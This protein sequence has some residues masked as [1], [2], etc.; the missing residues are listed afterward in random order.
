V[1]DA[2]QAPGPERPLHGALAAAVT[3]LAGGG[4]AV[5]TTGVARLVDFYAAAG[6]DGLLVLGTTGEGVLLSNDERKLVAR[7]YVRAAGARL[8]VAVHCGAQSSRDTVMLAAHAAAQGAAAVAVIP[9][10]YFVLD[11]DALLQHLSAAATACA[12][13][14]FYV[15]EFAARSG[16]AVPLAV[17]AALQDMA[18]NFVGLKVSDS[19]FD[20]VEPYLTGDL[21]VLVGAEGS[22]HRALAAGA[23][24]AV[25]G[26]AAALPELT[27]EAVRTGTAEASARAE[28]VRR[29]IERFPFHAALKLILQHR[30]VGIAALVRA[31]LRALTAGERDE[32]HDLLRDDRSELASLLRR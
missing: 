14:P 28:R 26:L 10:P 3:P 22:I 24:G 25:S 27:I 16:Y 12:P 1:I 21:D 15:Y 23:V 9:P 19:P 5:D 30:G 7:E 17:V 4:G 13:T 18:P 32:L 29:S 11:D 31:P 20:R 2:A 8:A 6:L